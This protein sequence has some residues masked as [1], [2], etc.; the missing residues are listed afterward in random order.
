MYMAITHIY[1]VLKEYSL[2]TSDRWIKSE[3]LKDIERSSFWEHSV[4]GED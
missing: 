3:F 4:T 1:S 2:G